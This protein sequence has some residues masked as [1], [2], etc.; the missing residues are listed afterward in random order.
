VSQFCHSLVDKSVC[1]SSVVSSWMSL[2]GAIPQDK[3]I[4]SFKSKHSCTKH[5]SKKPNSAQDDANVKLLNELL[6]KI[7]LSNTTYINSPNLD[8]IWS[9]DPGSR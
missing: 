3:I 5:I 6:L 2:D 8:Q 1:T 9:C 7:Q 4:Q